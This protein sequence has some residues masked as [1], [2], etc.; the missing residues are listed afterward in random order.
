[1]RQGS[2][3]VRS[4]GAVGGA[5]CGRA[6]PTPK[7]C[8]GTAQWEDGGL[9]SRRGTEGTPGPEQSGG[10]AVAAQAGLWRR[11]LTSGGFTP[12]QQLGPQAGRP[13]PGGR[14]HASRQCRLRNGPREPLWKG[15]LQLPVEKRQD[16]GAHIQEDGSR[17]EG[18][19]GR[20]GQGRREAPGFWLGPLGGQ[21]CR[22]DV[23]PKDSAT[24]AHGGRELRPT[25]PVRTGP[26]GWR[27]Q[28]RCGEEN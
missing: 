10:S 1:M 6:D 16:P 28:G 20:R 23:L 13:L 27:G 5:A 11:A 17:R 2:G 24:G 18:P 15:L 21:W 22:H 4:P 7:G 3:C 12:R 14:H 9:G 8:L 25:R 19:A 26:G